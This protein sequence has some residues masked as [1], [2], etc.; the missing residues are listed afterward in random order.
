M[1]EIEHHEDREELTAKVAALIA[2]TLKSAAAS[3]GEARAAL[4]GG[5][6]PVPVYRRLSED[7]SV[8]W[9]KVILTLSDERRVP[10][11]HAN[12][13]ARMLRETLLKGAAAKARF[14]NLAEG[15]TELER[16]DL[17]LLGMGED[18]HFASL[19]PDTEGLRRGLAQDASAVVEVTP[20]PLPEDAPHPRLSLS[21]R[22]I[23]KA[24]RIAVL[25]AGERKLNAF[26][27]ARDSGDVEQ[28]PILAL[29]NANHPDLTIHHAP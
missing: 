17:I 15:Q 10:E 8:P 19:F 11:D 3:R 12:S 21:L 29:L 22:T 24:R 28:Y 14:E 26:K 5:S 9:D 23:L 1:N 4:S 2:D 25:M 7:R 13:N 6:T 27:A 16:Q 20:D 18:G